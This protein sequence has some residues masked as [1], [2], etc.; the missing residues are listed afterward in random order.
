[1]SEKLSWIIDCYRSYNCVN[2]G[3]TN[4]WIQFGESKYTEKEVSSMDKERNEVED[5]VKELMSNDII[6]VSCCCQSQRTTNLGNGYSA[7]GC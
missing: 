1:M 6:E 7:S 5:V 3:S 4:K 2:I